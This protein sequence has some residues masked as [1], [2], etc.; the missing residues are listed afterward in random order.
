MMIDYKRVIIGLFVSLL[1]FLVGVIAKQRDIIRETRNLY[2]IELQ[3][4]E[5]YRLQNDSNLN[6]I[7]LHEMTISTLK[8][9][10]D[11]LDMKLVEAYKKLKIK[12]SKIEA[13]SY[14]SSIVSKT[15]TLLINDTIFVENYSLDTIVGDKWYNLDLHL[16]YPSFIEITPTFESERYVIIN[17]KKVYNGKKS[18]LFFIN[19]FKKKHTIIEVDIDERNPYIKNK[20]NRYVKVVK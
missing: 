1:V 6:V 15:D 4:V 7:G 13:L 19:W 18:W 5:A 2:N 20:A 10:N 14:Q 17:S 3:N 12:D 8:K 11:T 9:S 16:K